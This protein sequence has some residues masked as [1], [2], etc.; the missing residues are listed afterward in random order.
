MAKMQFCI[1]H[2]LLDKYHP[3]YSELVSVQKLLT[4]EI[5]ILSRMVIQHTVK[6]RVDPR[7]YVVDAY[8]PKANNL[9][10]RSMYQ[11]H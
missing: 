7:H 9:A 8:V 10:R 5:K 11:L 3:S 4:F 2:F 6:Q 1:P